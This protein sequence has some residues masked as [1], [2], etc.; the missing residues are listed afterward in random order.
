MDKW[1]L[2]SPESFL[3]V[4]LSFLIVYAAI[5]AFTRAAGLRSFSKMSA[6]DFAMTVAVGSLFGSSIATSS[7]P[8]LVALFA[9]ALLFAGQWGV[10]RARRRSAVFRKIVDNQPILLMRGSE[11]LE[12]NMVR[13]SV[14]EEDIRAKLREANVL[15]LDNIAAVVFE[16]T[17]DISVLHSSNG[18]QE[19]DPWLL[20]DVV[21]RDAE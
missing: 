18:A 13:S 19:L 3:W 4:L 11:L 8:L 7:P 12:E 21:G 2:A 15:N 14:T 9:F 20:D 10:A 6:S 5:I 16:T 17:G 1:V